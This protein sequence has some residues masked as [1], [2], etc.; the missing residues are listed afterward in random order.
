MRVVRHN[1]QRTCTDHRPRSSASRAW[2]ARRE[3]RLGWDGPSRRSGLGLGRRRRCL[4]HRVR[5]SPRGCAPDLRA[6]RLKPR[7]PSCGHAG[8]SVTRRCGPAPGERPGRDAE[9]CEHERYPRSRVQ[10]RAPL[11]GRPEP[12]IRC[13]AQLRHAGRDPLRTGVCPQWGAHVTRRR[14][15]HHSAVPTRSRSR[16]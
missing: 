6:L 11:R 1:G 14:G 12:Q 13:V 8:R 3:L 16:R 5:L 4:G 10:S 7:W 9:R 15:G 2:S